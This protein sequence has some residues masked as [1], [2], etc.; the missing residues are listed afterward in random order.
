[1]GFQG[2]DWRYLGEGA[3]APK[4]K[5]KGRKRGSKSSKKA[6]KTMT[7]D[8]H[9]TDEQ[10]GVSESEG[11]G[12][13]GDSREASSA[14]EQ[15]QDSHGEVSG[16]SKD[17]NLME[18]GDCKPLNE[19]ADA[20]MPDAA[21]ESQSFG[22]NRGSDKPREE[23]K[24]HGGSKKVRGMAQEEQMAKDTAVREDIVGSWLL[25]EPIP[26]DIEA[27]SSPSGGKAIKDD[28]SAADGMSGGKEEEGDAKDAAEAEAT[29]VGCNREG[30]IGRG[31][32][33]AEPEQEP[34]KG[35]PQA[36]PEVVHE[37]SHDRKSEEDAGHPFHKELEAEQIA[38]AA[39]KVMDQAEGAQQLA[40]CLKQEAKEHVTIEAADV[41]GPAASTPSQADDKG[42]N[43]GGRVSSNVNNLAALEKDQDQDREEPTSDNSNSHSPEKSGGEETDEGESGP[44]EAPGQTAEAARKK[45]EA[46]ASEVP[47]L[48]SVDSI[49]AE[50]DADNAEEVRMIPVSAGR[51]SPKSLEAPADD[52]SEDQQADE[53]T[54]APGHEADA[55]QENQATKLVV[56]EEAPDRDDIHE[57]KEETGVAHEEKIQASVSGAAAEAVKPEAEEPPRAEP[58]R[59]QLAGA[60]RADG[61]FSGAEDDD[62]DEHQVRSGRRSILGR[63]QPRPMLQ[64]PRAMCSTDSGSHEADGSPEIV[65]VT[66]GMGSKVGIPL[67]CMP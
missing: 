13:C 67:R 3:W 27:F 16:C 60:S 6:K 19:E 59:E 21:L 7:A 57:D 58:T 26:V 29:C 54:V 12:L 62:D 53:P 52:G 55:E 25:E 8:Q 41:K 42:R 37:H 40:K 14:M 48:Q 65:A 18:S 22:R 39:T 28:S 24:A 20:G 32:E 23:L 43:D 15:L 11:E 47:K 34:G 33:G 5:G 17:E 61:R 64:P 4:P 1:M 49:A 45:V 35:E 31:K 10:D 30:E 56:G 51:N 38:T 66:N 36:K 2:K 9:A 63:P 46:P 50:V 44:P